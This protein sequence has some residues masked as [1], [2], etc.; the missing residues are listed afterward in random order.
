MGIHWGTFEL[1]D[2]SLDEP[3]R[4][5]ARERSAQGV[6]ADAFFVTA[7]GETRRLVPRRAM[8]APGG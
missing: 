8:A 5:L 3:P 6:A 1:T 4:R 7:I 2:E